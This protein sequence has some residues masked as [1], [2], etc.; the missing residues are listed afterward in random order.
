MFDTSD[1]TGTLFLTILT[2]LISRWVV[3][4]SLLVGVRGVDFHT[5]SRNSDRVARARLPNLGNGAPSRDLDL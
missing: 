1:T 5:L 3:R 4:K 2:V